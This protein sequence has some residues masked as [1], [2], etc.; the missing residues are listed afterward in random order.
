[1]DTIASA[2]MQSGI[3]IRKVEGIIK[4][5]RRTER[6]TVIAVCVVPPDGPSKIRVRLLLLLQGVN[7][8]AYGSI[9]TD[10]TNVATP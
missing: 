8:L 1:M 9:R 10:N 4:A 6:L 7:N 3:L 2:N 5:Q